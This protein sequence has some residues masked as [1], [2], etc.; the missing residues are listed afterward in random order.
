M[1]NLILFSLSIILTK[2]MFAQCGTTISIDKNNFFYNA[3]ENP[4]TVGYHSDKQEIEIISNG[5]KITKINEC[6]FTVKPENN[7]SVELK[8]VNIHEKDTITLATYQYRVID[9]PNPTPFIGGIS[10]YDNR[11]IFKGMLKSNP[12]F[13]AMVSDDFPYEIKAT[14]L[15]LSVTYNVNDDYIEHKI[16]G[17]TIPENVLSEI[18]KL[19]AG[20]EVF[21]TDIII[22]IQGKARAIKGGSFILK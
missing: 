16:N 7:R 3:L 21:I 4:I 5:A 9:V 11:E 17:N 13:H 18:L 1:K 2:L 6:Q 19:D 10:L 20:C 14:I 12:N 8:I 15:S 22:N